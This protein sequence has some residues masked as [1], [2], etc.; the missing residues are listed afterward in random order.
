MDEPLDLQTDIQGI[1]LELGDILERHH[2]Y[3]TDE[4]REEIEDLRDRA[5]TL[6]ESLEGE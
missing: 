3:L 6:E 5:I 2:N 1:V 4:Q